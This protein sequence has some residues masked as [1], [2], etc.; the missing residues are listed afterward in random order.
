MAHRT[1]SFGPFTLDVEGAEL[2]KGD[3][4]VSIR[5]KCFDLLV[6]LIENA[7]RVISKEELLDKIWSDVVVN[8]AT[9]NRTVTELRAALGDNA[10]DPKYVKTVSRKGYKFIGEISGAPREVADTSVEFVLVYNDREFPLRNGEQIIGR[11]H[12]AAIPLYGKATSR[13]HARIIV[14]SGNVTLQDLGSRNGTY[15]NGIRVAGSIDLR[16]GDEIRI[17]ADRL[18]LWSRTSETASL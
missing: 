18:V 2:R 5:P 13:E 4:K 15:V 6:Y 11:G 7:G 8:D 3:E 16:S 1:F 12:G 10:D 14:A 9:L 17:G